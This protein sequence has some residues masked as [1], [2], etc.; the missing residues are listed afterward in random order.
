MVSALQ[1]RLPDGRGTRTLGVIQTMRRS[2]QAIPA[3]RSSTRPG[4]LIGVN[5]A[6][7][8]PRGRVRHWI[9]HTPSTWSIASCPNSSATGAPQSRDRHHRRSGSVA[10][11]LG[12]DGVVV[13]RV[14]RGSPAAQAGLRGVDPQAGT[15]ATSSW[16]LAT[17]PS[18]ASPDSTLPWRRGRPNAALE[19]TVGARRT[20]PSGPRHDDGC[21]GRTA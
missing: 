5:T 1:R 21:G 8:S 4:R 3:A 12:I 6:I 14:L 10:A 9:R 17:A 16:P 15:S 19:L 11:R 18:T 20:H 2:I 7:F 13:V